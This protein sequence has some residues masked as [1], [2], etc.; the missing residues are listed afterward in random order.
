MVAAMDCAGFLS[1]YSEYR[2][3]LLPRVEA[4]AFDGH[5]S[6]CTSCARYDRVIRLGS[7]EVAGLPPIA[8]SEDFMARLQHRL[9]TVDAERATSARAAGTS[10]M[11]VLALA[12]LLGIAAWGP[13][14]QPR[15]A[16]I[17]LPPVTALAPQPRVEVPLLYRT[18]PFLTVDERD[19][20][21]TPSQGGSGTVFFRYSPLGSG[22]V[23]TTSIGEP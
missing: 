10:S 6:S 4:E 7:R 19:V 3:G 2:D 12:A 13:L 21:A 16:V 18:G 17:V 20:S 14:M 8:P 11:L 15:K 1:E 23:F 22:S 9:Y 5:V